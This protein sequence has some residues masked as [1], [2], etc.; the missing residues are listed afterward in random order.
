MLKRIAKRGVFGAALVLVIGTL[1][2]YGDGA[3]DS[4]EPPSPPDAAPSMAMP[5]KPSK[6]VAN[7]PAC[8]GSWQTTAACAPRDISRH[9]LVSRRGPDGV[10]VV[11]LDAPPVEDVLERGLGL[12]GASPAHLAVRGSVREDSVRCHWRGIARTLSQRELA[13]R[14]W[15]DLDEQTALPNAD[16]VETL[17]SVTLDTLAPAFR[18]TA[19]SNF[20]AIARGGLSTEYVF[21][22]CY[23]SFDADEYILGNGPTAIVVAYDEWGE[24]PSYDLYRREHADG[25]LGAEPLMSEGEYEAALDEYLWEAETELTEIIEGREAVLFL[26]PMG[27][28]NAIA[29]EVWQVI[30]QWDLQEDDQGTVHAVRFETDEGDPEHTQTLANLKTRITTAAADDDFADD[31][32]ENV[33]ELDDYYDEIGAYDDITPDDGD[34][35]TFTPAQPPPVASCANGT[36]VPDPATNLPLVHD[37]EALIDAKDTLRGTVALDWSTSSAITGWEGI[38]TGGTPTRVTAL[39]LSSESLDGT[40]PALLGELYELT[41]LDL[42]SNSLT[43]EI[44]AAL[45]MLDNLTELR[46]SG[47]QLTGCIPVALKD[48]T[49]NDLSALNLLYCAPPPPENLRAGTALESSIPLSWDAVSNSSK[50]RVEYRAF[51]SSDWITADESLTTTSH[52]VDGLTCTSIY[53]FRVS[54]HGSGTTYVAV[55]SEPSAVFPAITGTCI[56]P[57]FSDASYSFDVAGNAALASIVGTVSASDSPGDPVSYAISAGNDAGTFAIDASTGDITVAMAIDAQTSSPTALTVEA[58]DASDST[59]QASVTIHLFDLRFSSTS[60]RVDEGSTATYS[61]CSRQA[62]PHSRNHR[63]LDAT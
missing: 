58:S 53:R 8:D 38:T 45:A 48:I 26:A 4:G 57:V 28:H 43:G 13:I 1:G 20:R 7:T 19:K 33:D 62:A 59:D 32:I 25:S 34:T 29:V 11:P 6:P 21:L 14:F 27:A 12:T 2:C 49:T 42:S 40:I 17:F 50:Y 44:P 18:E 55:W 16:Y 46:L 10:G 36:A 47:N 56:P 5:A 63:R 15:L 37:C 31:R 41:T 39:E 23:A 60:L 30:E 61:A 52:T 3:A 22:V 51:N 24:A 9:E 35:T 54:A